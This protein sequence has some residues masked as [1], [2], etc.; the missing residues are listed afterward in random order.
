MIADQERPEDDAGQAP[1]EGVAAGVDRDEPRRRPPRSRRDEQQPVVVALGVV[2]RSRRP[3]ASGSPGSAV[4]SKA[5]KPALWRPAV[6]ERLDRPGH[7]RLAAVLVADDVDDVGDRLPADRRP[8]CPGSAHGVD[9]LTRCSSKTEMPPST[10]RVLVV[11]GERPERDPDL[12]ARRRCRWTR[13]GPAGWRRAGSRR[14]SPASLV[15][16]SAWR[17][18]GR[19]ARRCAGSTAT[20]R[21]SAARRRRCRWP[22]R[23]R[24][25]LATSSSVA[26]RHAGVLL[27]LRDPVGAADS[28]ISSRPTARRSGSRLP[29]RSRLRQPGGGPRSPSRPRKA[30][31]S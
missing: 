21:E 15:R 17:R 7:R 30:V 28:R 11:G 22:G 5:A 12:Q 8:P 9:Q 1:G 16:A 18:P 13:I 27:E 26:S 19:R 14:R 10:G 29:G 4:V 23:S 20:T 25:P 31:R 2:A 24:S 6:A 3:I